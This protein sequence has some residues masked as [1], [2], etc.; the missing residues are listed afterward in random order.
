MPRVD[1]AHSTT[2]RPTVVNPTKTLE[3]FTIFLNFFRSLYA[4][5]LDHVTPALILAELPL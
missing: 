2:S 1:P 5:V 3:L 4:P